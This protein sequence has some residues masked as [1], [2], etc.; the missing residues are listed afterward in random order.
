MISS[1]GD[2]RNAVVD[3][4]YSIR[5]LIENLTNSSLQISLILDE[6]DHLIG[7]VSDGDI[8][9]GILAGLDLDSPISKI[10]QRKPLVVSEGTH[11]SIIKELMLANNINHMPIVNTKGQIKDLYTWNDIE[12]LDDI[13]IQ[14]VIMA[15]GKGKRLMPY[16]KDCPK[17]MLKINNK[18][19]LEIIIDRARAEGIKKFILCVNYL[20]QVI[21]EYFGNGQKFGVQIEYLYEEQELG[22]AGALYFLKDKIKSPFLVT[23]GDVITEISYLNLFNFHSTNDSLA[24]MAITTHEIH[25]PFG[26]VKLNGNNITGFEEKPIVSNFINCGIYVLD[27]LVIS[28]LVENKYC[29]MPNLFMKIKDKNRLH[30]YPIHEKWIDVGR[31]NDLISANKFDND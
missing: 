15:G 27:P 20:S 9:R 30:A 29:D 11:I 25:N 8:R 17:P 28:Y 31:E 12:S 5:E 3:D 14:M 23:N 24:T 10:I 16:T 21:V 2:W 22:T 6:D 26:V 1:K 7:T 19:M 4:G 18:P 13:N